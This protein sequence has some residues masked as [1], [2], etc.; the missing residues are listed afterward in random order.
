MNSC[1]LDALDIGILKILLANNGVPPGVPVFRKSFRSM[2]KEL[3]VD[4]A[5]IRSRMKRF[6][7]RGY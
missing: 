4:Q 6:R 1:E 7:S 5:T 3:R 2:A